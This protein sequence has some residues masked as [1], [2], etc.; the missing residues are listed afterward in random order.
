MIEMLI[1]PLLCLLVIFGIYTI[2]ARSLIISVI[3]LSIYSIT[4]T[5]IFLVLQAVD[6]AMTEAVIGA[7]LVTSFFVITIN[8]TEDIE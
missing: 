2:F 6:V 4:L 5:V 8:K 1:V 3:T 7:G